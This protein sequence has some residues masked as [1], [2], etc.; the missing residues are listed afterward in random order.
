MGFQKKVELTTAIGT[1][2]LEVNPGQ[3][4]Y[5]AFNYVSDGTVQAGTFAFAGTVTGNGE[6][7]GV[8]SFKTASGGALLGFVERNLTS[9]L[10][11]LE[12]GSN[13][14]SAGIGLNIAK[15]GQFYAVASAAAT[16]GQAVL[17]DPTTGAVTYG[18]AGATNDTGWTVVLPQGVT[19]V[20]KGD[21]VI[22][23]NLGVSVTPAASA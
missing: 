8:A 5:T 18:T 11:P 12:D 22:Y 15:R 4:V 9:A 13:V 6:K 14:Y 21:L 20:A 17:C 19:T 2:G 23:E 1:P 3:A 16:A 10:T 7:F